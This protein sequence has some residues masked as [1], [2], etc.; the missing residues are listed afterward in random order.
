MKA[1]GYKPKR[2]IRAVLYMNEENGAKGAKHYADLAK[3]KGEKHIAALESDRGGFA[4]RGFNFQSDEK[5][6][7]QFKG[8]ADLFQPY[9]AD[10]FTIG[11]G[12]VDIGFLKDQGTLLIG[13]EPDSQR[14]F[15]HHHA[16]TDVFESVDKRELQLGAASITALLYLIDKY[17]LDF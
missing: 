16:A 17:G 6:L 3:Q 4:P 10:R 14:Y 1:V 7:A 2:T 12:G 13:Y 5:T 9:Y 15:K 11:Y 8:F